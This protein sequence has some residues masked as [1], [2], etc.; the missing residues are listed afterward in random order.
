MTID[1]SHVSLR[2][3]QV[4]FLDMQEQPVS[5]VPAAFALDFQLW[6][7]PISVEAYRKFYYGVGR[8]WYWLDRMLMEDG[9]LAEMINAANV[10]IYVLHIEGQ[11]AGFAEFVREQDHV[12]I[13]YFG[14]LPDFIGKG[15]GHYFLQTVIQQAWS[16]Q[17]HH[18]QLNTCELDHPNALHVYRK[19]GFKLVRTAVEDR[20]I[21]R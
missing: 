15:Y 2:P 10:D 8:Q 5:T 16:Y 14:L 17:P 4:H 6:P 19:A 1:N 3:V 9:V 21:L 20:K 12:E 18:I 7:K 13:L 11:P